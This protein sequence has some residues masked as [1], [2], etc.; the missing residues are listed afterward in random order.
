MQGFL[1][2]LTDPQ[3]PAATVCMDHDRSVDRQTTGRVIEQLA[4]GLSAERVAIH[5]DSALHFAIALAATWH[6]NA[7]AILPAHGQPAYLQELDR[8]YDRLLDDDAVRS[9][10]KE[11]AATPDGSATTDQRP[12]PRHSEQHIVFYTSGSSGTPKAITRTRQQLETEVGLLESLWGDSIAAAACFHGLVSQQHI[13]GLLFRVFWPVM[14]GRPFAA[15]QAHYW[16]ELLAVMRSGDVLVASPAHLQRLPAQASTI[17]PAQV[18]CSGGPLPAADA[19]KVQHYFG[20]P[21]CEVYGS[22]ETGGIAWRRQATGSVWTP[23]PGVAVANDDEQRLQVTATHMHLPDDQ[24]GTWLTTDDRVRMAPDRQT[25]ELLGRADRI[26]KIEGK[27]VS[28]EQVEQRLAASPLVEQARLLLLAQRGQQLGAVV[29]LSATGRQQL[30][31]L[32]RFR[33]GR[34]LRSE[35]GDY[36][37]S[38][39]LP[40]HWRFV[41]ELPADAQSKHRQSELAALFDQATELHA[42]PTIETLTA[43]AE[44]VVLALSVDADLTHFRGHFPDQAVLP[45]VTQLHWAVLKAADHFTV[46]GSPS[47]IRQLKFRQVILPGMNVRLELRHET[48][49]A[50]VHF[51]YESDRGVHA[52]GIL[53]WD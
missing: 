38:A 36:E 35:L 48:A 47:R 37:E 2:A 7:L 33:L 28:L 31:Q 10:L 15:R 20:C 3:Q 1:E 6:N 51:R 19:N 14:T 4:A 17:R 49:R 32:G 11:T 53:H 46:S 34:R 22:T 26:V 27:R 50:C 39:A 30:T 52:S 16:E 5:C 40:R 29:K 44:H 25:F 12:D 43:T 23:L 18:F 41:T 13:Y 8:Q 45:G 42:M 24:T 21:P 9:V